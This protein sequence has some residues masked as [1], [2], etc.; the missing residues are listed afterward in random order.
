MSVFSRIRETNC[1]KIVKKKYNSVA[2]HVLKTLDCA[3]VIDCGSDP[4]LKTDILWPLIKS[5][6]V[7]NSG[8]WDLL[9]IK[10]HFLRPDYKNILLLVFQTSVRWAGITWWLIQNIPSHIVTF[11]LQINWNLYWC[12]P[13][14]SAFWVKHKKLFWTAKYQNSYENL[15][16]MGQIWHLLLY[17]V[18]YLKQLLPKLLGSFSFSN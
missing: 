13:S 17:V 7:I 11:L 8:W 6:Q 3:V 2:H 12:S 16:V 1:D 9:V 4:D 14:Y 18:R 10:L 15:I 5:T